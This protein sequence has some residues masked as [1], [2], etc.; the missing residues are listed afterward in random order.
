MSTTSPTSL[1]TDDAPSVSTGHAAP[2]Q[3]VNAIEGAFGRHA[4]RAVHAKGITLEG[5]FAP[6]AGASSVSSA[7]HLQS[8]SV[9]VV[10]RFSNFTG[11]PGGSDLAPRENPRGMA[12]K[13]YLPD[14]SATDIVAHS[15][16][17]FP[18]TTTEELRKLFL[19]VG[20]SKGASA[21]T[22][23]DEFFV[24]HPK[25]RAFLQ[26]TP[27]PMSYATLRYYGVNAFHFTNANGGVLH[28]RYRLDP[29]AGEHLLDEEQQTRVGQ[30]YLR[31]EIRERVSRVPVVFRLVLQIADSSDRLDDPATPWP[32]TR[33]LRELGTLSLRSL[34][35]DVEQAERTLR[36]SPAA[37]PAGIAPADPMIAGRDAAYRVSSERRGAG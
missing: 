5:E 16:N 4:A 22:P 26:A 14:G 27:P 23:A 9:R 30:D 6:S 21:P 35:T 1:A 36:F 12:V 8:T 18:A 24:T 32:E 33:A 10:V 3:V 31:E 34:V 37:V 11:L 28:G 17:G 7:P 25:A 2:S 15:Y 20:A 13:F 29:D 19:A